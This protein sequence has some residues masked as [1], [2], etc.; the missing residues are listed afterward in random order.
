MSK[1]QITNVPADRVDEIQRAAEESG[2]SVERL[3]E[4]GGTYTLVITRDDDDKG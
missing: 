4:P 2:A 3:P 1:K